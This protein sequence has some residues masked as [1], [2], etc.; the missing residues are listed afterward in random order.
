MFNLDIG[1][2]EVL[3]CGISFIGIMAFLSIV[4]KSSNHVAY[5]NEVVEY[6]INA[7]DVTFNPEK[8][9]IVLRN[10]SKRLRMHRYCLEIALF[11]MISLGVLIFVQLLSQYM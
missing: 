11:S 2:F 3:F 4:I 5:N 9:I 6:T 7:K 10:E 1:I 8:E